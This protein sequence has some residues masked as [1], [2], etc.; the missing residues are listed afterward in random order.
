M[1][2]DQPL[3]CDDTAVAVRGN[4]WNPGALVVCS[5]GPVVHTRVHAPLGQVLPYRRAHGEAPPVPGEPGLAERVR[6]YG[7]ALTLPAGSLGDTLLGLAAATALAQITPARDIHYHGPRPEL[8][9]RCVLPMI[10]RH[11]PG[12]HHLLAAGNTAAAVEV[13]VVPEAVPTWLDV[14]D[15]QRVAVHADL[16]MRY[17]LALEQALGVRLPVDHD[18]VPPFDADVAAPTAGRVVFVSCTSLP[19]RKDYGVPG[20][21]AVAAALSARRPGLTFTLVTAL[22]SAPETGPAPAPDD[23]TVLA[24]VQAQELPAVF[25][26][27]ELV[28][29]NDSGLTHLAALT[30]R[31][32]GTRPQVVGLYSRHAHTKWTTGGRNHHAVATRL[33]ALL[34]AADRC[35]V[36]DRLDDTLWASSAAITALP[37][38]DIAQAAGH[39]AGWW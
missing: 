14:L 7:W 1:R 39:A 6:R 24:G 22:D 35:P 5:G 27:A 13:P 20:F 30:R 17:Y 16:P 18:P 11:M 34:A 36:R 26:D 25:A 37:A 32:D 2:P 8:M 23:W 19:G 3:N 12:D 4:P 38:A 15:D 31:S 33:S 10:T 29:G 9:A 28:V 21:V